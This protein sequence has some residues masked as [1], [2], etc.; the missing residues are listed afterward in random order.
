MTELY[1]FFIYLGIRARIFD[2]P[3]SSLSAA[4]GGHALLTRWVRDYYQ[5]D[6]LDREAKGGSS[7]S[8]PVKDGP[9]KSAFEALTGSRGCCVKQTDKQPLSLQHQGHSRLVIGYE[10]E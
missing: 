7:Y 2:F 4:S 9:Q 1:T 10:G 3:K 8:S 6:E 5:K